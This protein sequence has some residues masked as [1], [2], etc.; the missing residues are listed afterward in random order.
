MTIQL[1]SRNAPPLTPEDSPRCG[2]DFL[3]GGSMRTCEVC[4]VEKSLD[5]YHRAKSRHL[6]RDYVCKVCKAEKN[7]VRYA[8]GK[9][10]MIA[11]NLSWRKRNPETVKKIDAKYRKKNQEKCAKRVAEYAAKYP[12]RVKA[13]NAVNN[14]I[15]GGRMVRGSCEVCGKPKANAH[16][17]DYSKPL[18]VRWLCNSHHKLHH[19]KIKS[20]TLGCKE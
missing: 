4:K 11:V 16:H 17:D 14:A 18:S 15:A 5:S 12:D 6:G 7:R 8:A 20:F 10:R 9:E 13:V 19:K 3:R 1:P 2:W